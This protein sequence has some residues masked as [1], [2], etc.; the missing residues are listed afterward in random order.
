MSKHEANNEKLLEKANSLPLCPGVYIMKNKAGQV[1]YVGKSRKLK[2][3]VSQYFQNSK[4]NTK[5]AR[6]V[7]FVEDFDYIVCHT[8]IEAL[9]LEN[10]LI[11]QYTPK[12]N[13]RLKDA[14][15]YP[16]IKITAEDYPRIIFTRSRLADR[17]KYFGPFSG[18]STVFSIL[19]L[20]HKSLGIP[21]CKRSFPKDIGK[22]RPCIYYQMNQCCGVCTGGVSREDYH[23]LIRMATDILRGHSGAVIQQLESRMY[24]LAEKER[25]EAAAQCRDTIKALHALRQKQNVVASPDTNMDVFGFGAA[26]PI[27]CISVMYVRDGA[28]VNKNDFTFDSAGVLEN[29]SL[30]SFLVDHYIRNDEIPRMILLSFALDSEELQTMED[31]L[32]ERAGYRVTVRHPVRGAMRELCET[33]V[34]NAEETARQAQIKAQ[35]DETVLVQ[36]ANLLR[37]E[38]IPERIEAYDISNIG[39]ENITAGMVV[40]EKGKSAKSQYRS[41]TIQ[42]VNGVDDYGSMREALSRRFKRYATEEAGSFATLPDLLLVD[43]GRNHVAV[44]KEVLASLAL[45]VPVFGMVKDEYHKTRALCTEEEEINIARE[46]AVYMLI[47]AIQEEVHRFTVGRTTN[48][49]RKTLRHS[50]LEKIEGI[51]PVKAKKLLATM[52]TLSA[53]KQA[54][55]EELAA[56]SGITDTDAYRV[57]QHFH[58]SE[59]E[60][61]KEDF[62]I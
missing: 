29:D 6:M 10:S 23:E 2:N 56:I 45:S 28:V 21:N 8:E 4:K 48:A 42:S 54:S 16:Y 38:T 62:K 61:P 34:K 13:I 47:Y 12:Y 39:A 5:T 11:K 43:G 27:A 9:T 32:S 15:T 14:K 26:D 22:E 17:A 55:A 52:G 46:K 31:F 35:K 57:Y 53:I 18:T 24:T 58:G 44:A 19:D 41:F 40:F 7:Y 50:S 30:S 51:G 3:R 33:V 36:L 20:L 25:F 59:G 1:I 60:D 37:L 49:K